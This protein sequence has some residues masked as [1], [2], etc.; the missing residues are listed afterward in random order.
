VHSRSVATRAG[1]FGRFGYVVGAG[2][3][4]V[5]D[6]GAWMVDHGDHVHYYRAAIRAV[7]P[8]PGPPPTSVFS[9]PVVTAVAHD[10]GTV[11]LLD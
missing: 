3:V 7:G 1:L 2:A 6:S 11:T 10:D 4:H 8:V 5:V 9:D